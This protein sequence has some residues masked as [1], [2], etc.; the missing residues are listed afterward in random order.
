MKEVSADFIRTEINRLGALVVETG[1]FHPSGIKLHSAGDGLALAESRALHEAN[2]GKL[3]LLEFGEDERAARKSLGI[4]HVLAKNV[5]VGDELAEDIRTPAGELLLAAGTKFDESK[6]AHIQSASLLAVPIRHRKLAE[7][8]KQAEAYVAKK[9][10][11]EGK[12][13]KESGS[14][15]IMRMTHTAQTPVRYLLIP[16]ARV[17]VGVGDDL[18]RTL[19]VNGLTS[20]G[21]EAVER[22]SPGAAVED[23]FTERPHVILMD[24]AESQSPLQR[25]RST[26]GVRNVAVVVCA[27]DPK[28]AQLT[29]ALHSGANDW[30]PRPPSRDLLNDKIKGCQDLL[31]R[32]VQLAPSLRTERRKAQR[33]TAKGEAELKDPALGKPLPVFTGDIVDLTETGVRIAYNLP[34]WPCPWAYTV[35]GVHPRHAFH[36]Y[37]LSNLMPRDLRVTLPGPKGAVE[38]P[39]RVVHIS[40]GMNNTEVMGLTF[41]LGPEMQ[42]H[43]STTVRK[44]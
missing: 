21:H 33:P 15:R 42:I 29:N 40:P 1:L 38:K 27:E 13:P 32:K 31:L 11:A 16:R 9:A 44:F 35:H 34:K 22:K 26:E 14:T 28:S 23:V 19:L 37:A 8:T 36:P 3:F 5:D 18:L 41:Q 25:L 4:E 10:S 6:L 43:R 30:I 2:F 17:L 7:M 20:E 24:L 12:A 39:A